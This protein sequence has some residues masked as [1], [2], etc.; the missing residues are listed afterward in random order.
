[1]YR[2]PPVLVSPLWFVECP[3]GFKGKIKMRN[4][5]NVMLQR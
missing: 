2:P 5:E 1:M 3:V 4:G